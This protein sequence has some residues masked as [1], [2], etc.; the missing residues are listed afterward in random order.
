MVSVT[1]VSCGMSCRNRSELLPVH[2]EVPLT[3]EPMEAEAVDELPPAGE[4][5]QFEPKVDG[6][7][8]IIFRD[9]AQIQ[10]K[11][12]PICMLDVYGDGL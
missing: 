7:R 3:L 1:T 9:G 4:G 12:E 8:C 2:L 6:F 10:R 5:W 11:R